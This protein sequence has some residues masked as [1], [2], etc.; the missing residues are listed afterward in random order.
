MWF[1]GEM[2]SQR[3]QLLVKAEQESQRGDKVG[4]KAL[5]MLNQLGDED[6]REVWQGLGAQE[7]QMVVNNI[8]WYSEQYPKLATRIVQ[9]YK[10]V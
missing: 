9:F 3:E 10:D 2:E 1:F 6:F 8:Q 7:R 5:D 4:R